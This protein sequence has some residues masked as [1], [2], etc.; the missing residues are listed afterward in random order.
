[1]TDSNLIFY[2]KNIIDN[3]KSLYEDYWRKE[4]VF[5]EY[6]MLLL[7]N[8][9]K[10]WIKTVVLDIPNLD[11]NFI[12]KSA[13]KYPSVE[14]IKVNK[15]GA[16]IKVRTYYG[17][18]K[19]IANYL[20]SIPRTTTPILNN[21]FYNITT[22]LSLA[23]QQLTLEQTNIILNSKQ[24]YPY[25]HCKIDSPNTL[26]YDYYRDYDEWLADK[27]HQAKIN[28]AQREYDHLVDIG[29]IVEDPNKW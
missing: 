21:S 15:L 19:G 16:W 28:R 26:E 9:D 25:F 8:K 2:I 20:K 10:K 14:Y 11:I 6:P 1:M 27:V 18:E 3:L 23:N 4:E 24:W 12:L 17:I 13:E 22:I 7:Y 5:T 29:K